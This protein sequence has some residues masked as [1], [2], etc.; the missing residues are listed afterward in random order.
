MRD[1]CRLDQQDPDPSFFGR[2]SPLSLEFGIGITILISCQ[3]RGPSLL[4][5]RLEVILDEY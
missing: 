4:V 2:F 5:L 1:E 3:H